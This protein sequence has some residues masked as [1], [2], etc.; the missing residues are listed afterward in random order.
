MGRSA[1]DLRERACGFE[2]W[3]VGPSLTIFPAA[4]RYV[5]HAKT[6]SK[7]RLSEPEVVVKALHPLCG[8]DCA[9]SHEASPIP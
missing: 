8:G 9:S 4:Y 3:T 7:F 2:C 1:G 5:S 6:P